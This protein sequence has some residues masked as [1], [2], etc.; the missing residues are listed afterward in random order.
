[1]RTSMKFHD[2]AEESR[3]RLKQWED[4]KMI[5]RMFSLT[6]LANT[7]YLLLVFY[8]LPVSN[9]NTLSQTLLTWIVY[10]PISILVVMLAFVGPYRKKWIS[11]VWYVSITVASIMVAFGVLLR[12]FLCFY[13]LDPPVSCE[14]QNRPISS[15]NYSIIYVLLGP[16]LILN[17]MN[18]RLSYQ[19][20]AILLIMVMVIWAI[21]I[22]TPNKNIVTYFGILFI[23]GAQ[24]MAILVSKSREKT[25]RARYLADVANQRL[26]NNLSVEVKQKTEAQEKAK[27]E[28]DRRTQ[29]TSMLFHE[30]RVPLNSVILSMNDLQS[31]DTVTN[32]LSSDARETLRNMDSGLTSIVTILNDSLDFRKMNEGKYTI[33]EKP[34]VYHTMVSEVIRSMGIKNVTLKMDLDP[35]I[36]EIPFKLLGDVQRLGQ[37][38]KNYLS[39]AVKFTPA[40]GTITVKTMIEEKNDNRVEIYTHV[41]DTGIGIKKENQGKLFKPFVQIDPEKTQGGK[42]TGLGLSIVA[43]IINGMGGTYGLMSEYGEGSIFWFR[44]PLKITNIPKEATDI[45]AETKQDVQVSFRILVT[46]DEP[47]TRKT[48][49]RLLDRLGHTTE[50]AVD[51]VDCLEKSEQA[52]KDK[53]PFDVIFIDNIMPRMNGLE[54]IKILKQR[55]YPA[56]II[57]LTGSGN[58]G[59]TVDLVKAGADRVIIK[60]ASFPTIKDTLYD[61]SQRRNQV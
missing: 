41:Q 30:M 9:V 35:R 4:D 43:S 18:N 20:P 39:N 25:Q 53:R 7:I 13:Q 55:K 28:E 40:G 24:L 19:I 29:F 27:E 32:A 51:G 42:G 2:A 46:D 34:F 38:I 36:D 50:E 33:V 5:I 54:T 58:G 60:P 1:M 45:P 17:I 61:I 57:S 16:F 49:R 44:V 8:V 21:L 12:T 52:L 59:V 6:I 37:V 26:N 3:Y 48:M 47:L 14:S 56:I 10:V 31:D 11:V 15:A 22:V 23:L